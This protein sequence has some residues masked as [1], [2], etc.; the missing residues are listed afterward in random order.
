MSY[1]PEEAS[2]ALWFGEVVE[3]CEPDPEDRGLVF[4]SWT[5]FAGSGP[6]VAMAVK[7]LEP[8]TPLA[9]DLLRVARMRR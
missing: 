5:R 3:V 1:P 6:R 9:R 8:I 7:S 4:V 2:V